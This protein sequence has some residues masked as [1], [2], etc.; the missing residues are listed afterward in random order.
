MFSWILDK[1]F[2]IKK[3]LKWI[4]L[5]LRINIL[6]SLFRK[7]QRISN[8][9]RLSFWDRVQENTNQFF[10][11][12]VREKSFGYWVSKWSSSSLVFGYFTLESLLR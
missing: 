12:R 4:E 5:K 9:V 11:E 6:E 10:C 2:K 7:N 8:H 3:K 1:V